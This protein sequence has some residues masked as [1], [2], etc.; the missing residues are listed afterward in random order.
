MLFIQFH[1]QWISCRGIMRV[2]ARGQ[3]RSIGAMVSIP[4]KT[5]QPASAGRREDRCR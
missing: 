3:W 5:D 4:S 1:R 2:V